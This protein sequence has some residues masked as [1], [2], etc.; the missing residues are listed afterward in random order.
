MEEYPQKCSVHGHL[1][2]Y[3]VVGMV[4][5]SLSGG[6][7]QS[8][9]VDDAQGTGAFSGVVLYTVEVGSRC[10]SSAAFSNSSVLEAVNDESVS[11]S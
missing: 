11:L 5:F 10:R 6:W 9:R 7:Y 1:D 8:G 4:A 2:L 3:V